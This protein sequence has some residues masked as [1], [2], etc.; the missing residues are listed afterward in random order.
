M[1]AQVPSF[2]L[3][4][5]SIVNRAATRPRRA[6]AERRGGPTPSQ[7]QAARRLRSPPAPSPSTPAPGTGLSAGAEKVSAGAAFDTAGAFQQAASG[8]SRRDGRLG[9]NRGAGRL[10]REEREFYRRRRRLDQD[11]WRQLE[12]S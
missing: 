5:P 2:E 12:H 6:K 8:A 4:G 1:A 11:L 9:L 7:A 3:P 10:E